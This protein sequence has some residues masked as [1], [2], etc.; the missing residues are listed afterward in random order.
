MELT[1]TIPITTILVDDRGTPDDATDDVL[2]THTEYRIEVYDDGVDPNAAS[3]VPSRV[4]LSTD[5]ELSEDDTKLELGRTAEAQII[6]LDPGAEAIFAAQL[7][8]AYPGT[9]SLFATVGNPPRHIPAE[10]IAGMPNTVAAGL[11]AAVQ[12]G[13][14]PIELV[15]SLLDSASRRDPE[16][17]VPSDDPVQNDSARAAAALFGIALKNLDSNPEAWI[18]ATGFDFLGTSWLV[19][20]G[21]AAG[22]YGG[23]C[24]QFLS[25]A[26]LYAGFAESGE[27][28]VSDRGVMY[29]GGY[30]VVG[31]SAR[32][33][34]GLADIFA[35]RGGTVDGPLELQ[36]GD[37]ILTDGDPHVS[38]VVG[39]GDP[40]AVPPRIYA[41]I[42]EAE[43]E[44]G[45]RANLVPYVVDHDESNPGNSPRPASAVDSGGDTYYVNIGDPLNP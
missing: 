3:A 14:A 22:D 8:N 21:A 7:A 29:S 44:Y 12:R 26:Y 4:V 10:T 43:R 42:E 20:Q 11:F 37:M 23:N 38:M 17:T 28:A 25:V 31:G 35:H 2:V 5:A 19:A 15:L 33:A 40:R 39:F 9:P 30:P 27:F 18:A 1:R 36:V 41:T 32:G 6:E 13:D 45:S 24:A 16:I 34:I